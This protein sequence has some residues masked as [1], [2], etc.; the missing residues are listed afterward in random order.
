MIYFIQVQLKNKYFVGSYKYF[1]DY[2]WD[3]NNIK[4]LMP[5]VSVCI[6]A[7]LDQLTSLSHP[8]HFALSA[9]V[10]VSVLWQCCI[11][12]YMHNIKKSEMK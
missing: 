2:Y 12:K 4:S 11:K 7:I 1:H 6:D 8:A 3:Q 9:H 10:D 5:S